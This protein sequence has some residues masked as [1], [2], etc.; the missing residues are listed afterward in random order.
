MQVISRQAAKAA[1]LARYFTGAVCKYGHITE[2]HTVDGHCSGCNKMKY[3]G[4][5]EERK[6]AVRTY[7]RARYRNSQLIRE[8]KRKCRD[9]WR[10]ENR[11][12]TR[13]LNRASAKR[14]RINNPD[15]IR[16][17]YKRWRIRN[18]PKMAAKQ[19]KRR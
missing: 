14:Q 5:S 8:K 7:E 18:L 10:T 3:E 1:G 11:E 4:R 9:D 6:E 2:R 15:G 12:R 13:E 19:A 16:A 17:S